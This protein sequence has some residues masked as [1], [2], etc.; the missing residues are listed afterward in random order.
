MT[1][2]NAA[3][4]SHARSLV[5]SGSVDKTSDWSFSAEDGNALLG[6]NGDDWANYGKWFLGIDSSQAAKSKAYYKY[7]FGKGGKVYR[8]AVIAIKQR[9]AQENVAGIE[10]EASDLLTKIDGKSA[11]SLQRAYARLS[12]KAISETPDCFVISGVASSPRTDRMGDVVEPMGAQFSS[13]PKLFLYHDTTLPIGNVSQAKPTSKGIPFEARIPKVSESGTVK[14]RID[15]AIHSIKYDLLSYVSIGFRPLDDEPLDKANPYGGTRFKSW[16]WLELSVVGV[17]ANPDAVITGIKSI[18]DELHAA[19]VKQIK[20]S[21]HATRAASGHT[22]SRVVS[23]S[24]PPGAS[25]KPLETPRGNPM[26]TIVEQVAG[27]EAKRAANVGRMDELLKA[28]A[29]E[30]RTFDAAEKEEYGNLETEIKSVDEHLVVLRAAVERNKA[31]A[32]PVL[33]DAGM[34]E[35]KPV[36]HGDAI[37]R[38]TNLP[39]GRKF[40]RLAM[41][42]AAARGNAMTAAEIAR[43]Q[44]GWKDQSPD[45]ENVLRSWQF[46]T[47]TAVASGNTTD[48]N[49]AS[50][51]VQFTNMASEFVDLLRP[52][53][54]LGKVQGLRMVPFNIRFATQTS[55]V[56]VGWVGQ[57]NAIP[58]QKQQYIT[59]TIGFAKI[60]AIV[61]ITKE[62]AMFSSPAAEQLV[63]DDL[64][65]YTATFMD[66][67][68]ID[69]S[70]VAS[71]NVSPASITNG[72][73]PVQ[74]SAAPTTLAS[75]E[76]DVSALMGALTGANVAVDNLVWVMT[77]DSAFRIGQIRTANGPY[78]FPGI[79][80]GGGTLL[81]MPVITSNSV[82]HS[83]SAGSIIVLFNPSDIFMADEGGV[84]IDASQEASVQMDSAPSN[85]AASLIS[86]WQ[87][88]LLG[89][90]LER[91]VNWQRRRDVSVTYLD[92]AHFS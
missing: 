53:T 30:G 45:I 56:S 60:A 17:P 80:V 11:A 89:I 91:V 42:M 72:I 81:S 74:A 49:Y 88:G 1:S 31:S 26:S 10:S 25:G 14:D 48:T 85:S 68:F 92:N 86:L 43:G 51:L 34:N 87:S 36:R 67:Q 13:L 52:A 16:E 23:L 63:Q 6:A 37:I 33:P 76:T 24:T 40:A 79:T 29:D 69:P 39:K 78:A 7:P 47:R 22:R 50:P 27:F 62:L 2:L 44:P 61:A 15:E 83:T 66:Q 4:A 82:P 58:A 21:D 20:S 71:A 12:T 35:P 19:R 3:G 65:K 75:F 18:D 90:R 28:S 32:K 8:S 59:S 77:P 5:A 57:G 55:G 70:V 38:N 64:T 46:V 54:I 73:T 9:A 41:C 84:E